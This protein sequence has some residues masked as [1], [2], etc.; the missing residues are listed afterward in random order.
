MAF[1]SLSDFILTLESKGELIRISQFVNPE[2]EISEIADRFS[3]LPG[4]GKALLFENT[5]TGFPVL[6]NSLGSETRICLALGIQHLDDIAQDIAAILDLLSEP[7]QTWLQ[8][9]SILPSLSRYAGFLPLKTVKKA[10]CQEVILRDPDLYSL[11]VLKTWPFDGGRFFTFPLVHTIDPET[12]TR[13]VGMYRM[14]VFDKNTTG[15]H[16]HRHKTGASHF[17]KY[18]KAGKIMP[19]AVALGGD[20]VLTYCATAPLPDQLDEYIFAGFLRKSPVR[21]IKAI[22]QNIEVP[23]DADIII[24]GYINPEE[25]FHPEGPFG[26]HTGFYSLIDNYPVFHITCITHRKNAV[27]PATVVGIPPMEDAWIAK[28]TERIFLWPIK[29]TVVPEMTDMNIPEFGVAHNLTI[30]SITKTFPGQAE[31][32]INALWGAGQMMFNKFMVVL[33]NE[34]IINNYHEIL[35][36]FSELDFIQHLIF[37]KG[38]LDVLDHSAQSMGFGS[39]MGID[40]TMSFPEEKQSYDRKELSEIQNLGK[41]AN[42]ILKLDYLALHFPGI[43]I[44]ILNA[45]KTEKKSLLGDVILCLDSFKADQPRIVLILDENVDITDYYLVVWVAL[46]NIDPLRDISIIP[47]KKDYILLLDATTKES[48]LNSFTR[49]WPNVIVMDD[50]TIESIDKNWGK[51]IPFKFI[52]SP[53]RR[54]KKLVKNSGAEAHPGFFPTH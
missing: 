14:Q 34:E 29:K 33:D 54:F 39:K 41:P 26:D 10:P 27:F 3:K 18:K 49:P 28:A 32:V 4:G 31:K 50:E 43:R 11:P 40:L 8:K 23:A 46:N 22:T 35:K 48:A 25:E 44:L 20:P 53:S 13:N 36:K 45:R 19:V 47:Y 1:S 30:T 21:L 51:L 52:E 16:W 9:F 17:E 5:G 37:T 2:L 42:S 12:G 24:E 38:P 6:I 7:R 15:M